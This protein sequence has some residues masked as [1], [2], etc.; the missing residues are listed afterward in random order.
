[1]RKSPLRASVWV[2]RT[3]GSTRRLF[4]GGLV[5]RRLFL[6]NTGSTVY[7]GTMTAPGLRSTLAGVPRPVF[8]DEPGQQVGVNEAPVAVAD[9]HADDGDAFLV[10][11]SQQGISPAVK[12]FHHAAEA[13]I[14]ALVVTER[15]L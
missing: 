14:D 15:S 11:D 3:R 10:K 7:F 12:F 9:A 4:A 5:R 6:A 2:I 13:D 1:M 8:C